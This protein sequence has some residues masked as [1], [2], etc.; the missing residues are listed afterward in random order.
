MGGKHTH[1]F[2][3][4][5][6]YTLSII[7]INGTFIY[8]L[9]DQALINIKKGIKVDVLRDNNTAMHLLNLY[10]FEMQLVTNNTQALSLSAIILI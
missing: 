7:I 4:D 6:G 10:H 9:Y 2:P 1:P 8:R 3:T 5:I